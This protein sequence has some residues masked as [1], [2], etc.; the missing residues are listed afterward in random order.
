MLRVAN[1]TLDARVDMKRV[2]L[3]FFSTFPRFGLR[4]TDGSVVS[5]VFRD[6]AWQRTDSLLTFKRCLLMVNPMDYLSQRK[7][8]VHRLRIDSASVYVYK[9]K[10]GRANWNVMKPDT[11]QA[12]EEATSDTTSFSLDGGI[13]IRRVVFR[14]TNLVFDDRDT[15]VYARLEDANLTLKASL[16]KERS[17]LAMEFDNRNILFWQNDQLLVNHL[18]TRLKTDLELDRTQRTLALNNAFLSVNGIELDVQGTLRAD[19][20]ARAL[21]MDLNY[22]LH[23]PSLETV[24]HLIPESVLK[25]EEVTAKGEVGV[26]GTLRGQYGH[27]KMPKAT[28]TVQIKQASAKY[29]RMPYGVDDITADFYSEVDL[30]RRSPSFADLK[31]FRFKGAHTDILADAKV[32]DLLGDPDITFHTVSKVDLT[33]LAKT[34]PLQEGV[35]IE[36]GLDADLRLHCRLSSLQKRDIG[37]I[38][39]AGRLAMHDFLLRDVNKDFEFT[40]NASLAFMGNDL[41]AA[42]PR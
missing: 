11:V 29:A 1:Q 8:T 32:E 17:L 26:K 18:S 4:L 41:L 9:S 38:K 5:E 25:K 35:T 28:L 31:I 23:A 22:G 6:S 3:T 14:Q 36:G 37:R 12:E 16:E 21:D 10:E 19:T 42:R 40:S 15:R 24:L 20:T 7:L 27:G 30:M 33:A 2:E 39:A 34:F 13:D